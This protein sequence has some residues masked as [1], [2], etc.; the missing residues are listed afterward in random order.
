[1]SKTVPLDCA[2]VSSTVTADAALTPVCACSIEPD[3]GTVGP[4]MRRSASVAGVVL[5]EAAAPWLR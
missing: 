4:R 3:Y 2:Q 1:M 5:G